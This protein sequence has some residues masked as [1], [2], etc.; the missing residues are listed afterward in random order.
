MS[1]N[2]A[3]RNFGM[4]GTTLRDRISGRVEHGA[5][6]GRILYLTAKEDQELASFLW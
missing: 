4:P 1:V 5:I 2:Q 3:S 6:S